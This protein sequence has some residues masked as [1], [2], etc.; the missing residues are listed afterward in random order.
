M[1]RRTD[2][3]DPVELDKLAQQDG[4]EVRPVAKFHPIPVSSYIENSLSPQTSPITSFLSMG[5]ASLPLPQNSAI[6]SGLKWVH[7]LKTNLE[8]EDEG[9]QESLEATLKR[10]GEELK[11]QKEREGLEAERDAMIRDD[12]LDLDEFAIDAATHPPFAQQPTNVD[13]ARPT[14]TPSEI[15][16]VPP[17]TSISV[18]L[19]LVANLSGKVMENA[20]RNVG[21]LQELQGSTERGPLDAR[22]EQDRKV[23]RVRSTVSQDGRLCEAWITGSCRELRSLT[24]IWRRLD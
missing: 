14:V 17:P 13:E 6:S 10:L 11:G 21:A 16:E 23:R 1:T 15:P 9:T 2:T 24:L 4:S 19:H 12:M 5:L 8:E 22:D 3:Y 7:S 18:L 20:V